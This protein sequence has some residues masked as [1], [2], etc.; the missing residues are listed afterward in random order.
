MLRPLVIA[1]VFGCASILAHGAELVAKPGGKIKVIHGTPVWNE[2]F[3]DQMKPGLNWRL[4]S[5][6]ATTLDTE[7]GIIFDDGIVFPGKYN[8]G[9]L[10]ENA[11]SYVLVVHNDGQNFQNKSFEAKADFKLT[12]LDKKHFAKALAIDFGRDPE[13]KGY[14]FNI[15]FGPHRVT[16]SFVTAKAKTAKG[17]TGAIGFTATYLERTDLADFKKAVEGG[18]VCVAKFESKSKQPMKAV[19]SV[20]GEPT[21]RFVLE[22]EASSHASVTGT[23]EQPKTVGTVLGLAFADQEGK[24]KATFSAGDVNYVFTIDE[25]PF[26]SVK[27]RDR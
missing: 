19:L 25:K 26:E 3:T 16:Q 5:N 20:R 21:L 8:L 1:C 22:G 4:G 11:G 9:L 10:C 17:K 13:K 12:A 6:A 24:A 2:A 27:P 7:A 15:D 23:S 18:E 14:Q